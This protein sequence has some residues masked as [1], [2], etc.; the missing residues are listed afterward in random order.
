VLILLDA[1]LRMARVL[2]DGYTSVVALEEDELL[3][4]ADIWL[5]RCA[6]SL[7]MHT[8]RVSTALEPTY[9]SK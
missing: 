2:L 1:P 6:I 7:L 5:V 3:I 9:C 8:C 4:L